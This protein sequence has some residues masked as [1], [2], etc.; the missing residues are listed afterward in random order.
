MNLTL[1][2]SI[3]VSSDIKDWHHTPCWGY[4]SGPS[5]RHHVAPDEEDRDNLYGRT[6]SNAAVYI[7]DV[8]IT[9]AF[10]LI[11]IEQFEEEWATRFPDRKACGASADVFYNGTLVFRDDF[12]IVDGGRTMLPMPPRRDTLDVPAD[13]ARFIRLLDRFE[14]VSSFDEYFKRAGLR[15]N[16]ETWPVFGNWLAGMSDSGEKQRPRGLIQ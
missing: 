12:V 5:Y 4:G 11:W 6:H 9:L 15:L 7:P 8:S 3:V 13:H 16:D 10:G 1:L 2:M 14:G